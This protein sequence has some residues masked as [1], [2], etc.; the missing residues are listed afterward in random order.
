[1]SVPLITRDGC[2]DGNDVASL[3][4]KAGTNHVMTECG[5]LDLYVGTKSRYNP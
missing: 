1:M 4:R 5:N 2:G 3:P